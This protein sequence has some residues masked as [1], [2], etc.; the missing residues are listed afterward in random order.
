[1]IKIEQVFTQ[2]ECDEIIL[3]N[4]I[5]TRHFHVNNNQGDQTS[6]LYKANLLPKNPKTNFVYKKLFDFFEKASG[7]ALYRYPTEVYIMKYEVGDKFVAH[8]DFKYGRVFSVGVQLNQSYAGG[9]Y[10]AYLPNN[11]LIID[12]TP[13]TAYCME[14][15]TLHEVEQITEVV[16]YSLVTFIHSTDLL[17]YGK[18]SLI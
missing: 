11:T 4:S 1:M 5:Y 12:K 10:Y 16:R 6:I 9:N 3:F 17:N 2:E 14:V 7:F 8:T 13:G 18:A 15:S